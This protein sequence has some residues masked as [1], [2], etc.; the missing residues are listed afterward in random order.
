MSDHVQLE[1]LYNAKNMDELREA[2]DEW[3]KTYDKQIMVEYGWSGPRLIAEQVRPLLDDDAAILDAGAG[4][5]AVGLEAR[6]LGFTTMDALDLSLDMLKIAKEHGVYR[7][8]RVGILGE[9][10]DYATDSYDA[11]LS[12]GTFTPGHA[13]PEGFDELTRIV[14]PGG[15]ICFTLRDD[16][17]PKGFPET[18]DRLTQDG[19][20][21]KEYVSEPFQ[22]MPGGE[23]EV[24]HRVW[25]F[26]V[27]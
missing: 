19:R 20:W 14:K 10:L 27:I 25:L 26:R 18:F 21:R 22:G 3:A 1:K 13:P 11:V 5:G 8:I 16:V 2:Y 7:D 23:P 15:V 6:R 9:P 24:R 12:A 17:V 4:T